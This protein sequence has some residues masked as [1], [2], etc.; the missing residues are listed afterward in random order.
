MVT[1]APSGGTFANEGTGITILT[2]VTPI[3]GCLRA[4]VI[5]CDGTTAVSGVSGG[6]VGT[7]SN[8]VIN[9]DGTNAFRI[10]IWWGMVTSTGNSPTTLTIAWSASVSTTSIEYVSQMFASNLK[11]PRWFADVTGTG[12]S[13]SSAALAYPTL[14]PTCDTELYFGY[15]IVANT[16]AAGS[17]SGFTYVV[18]PSFT[19]VLAYNAGVSASVSPAATQSPA[20]AY[21]T[22]GV[23]FRVIDLSEFFQFTA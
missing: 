17:T 5:S 13:S 19:N 12:R 18:T 21:D 23:M 4:L 3:V 11:S 9:S 16:G 8:A 6:G 10:E 22:A 20:G 1:I 2:V 14:A 15:T 7:W